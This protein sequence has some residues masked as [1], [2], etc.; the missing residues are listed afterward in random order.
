[1]SREAPSSLLDHPV[2]CVWRLRQGNN[3]TPQLN[4]LT[5]RLIVTAAALSLSLSRTLTL[6]S[7]A[8]VATQLRIF[9]LEDPWR[10]SRSSASLS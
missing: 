3:L 7:V 5:W 9:T 1:M 2:N 8:F 4:N 10:L 6:N